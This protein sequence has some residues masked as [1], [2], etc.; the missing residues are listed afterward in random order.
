MTEFLRLFTSTELFWMAFAIGS[1]ALPFVFD[2]VWR[3]R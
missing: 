3:R 1:L 2:I